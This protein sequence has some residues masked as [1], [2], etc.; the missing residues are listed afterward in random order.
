[1]KTSTCKD[2]YMLVTYSSI[3]DIQKVLDS[4]I[5]QLQMYAF[6]KHDKDKYSKDILQ[7]DTGEVLHKKG[8]IEGTHYHIFLKLK[9]TRKGKEIKRWFEK[10]DSNGIC[11]NN[12]LFKQVQHTIKGTIEYLTHT[13]KSCEGYEEY[14]HVYDKS[15]IFS[16]NIDLENLQQYDCVNNVDES[17]NIILD[18]L[19]GKSTR[20]L[21][22]I[23]G[24]D[25]IYHKRA[26]DEIVYQ[27]QKEEYTDTYTLNVPSNL[28]LESCL[29][30]IENLK[31]DNVIIVNEKPLFES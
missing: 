6:I 16:Y 26:Y 7:S 30:Q 22:L 31:N 11:V 19:A 29:E 21:C 17:Y 3:E 10:F 28:A 12:C 5:E 9:R 18:I 23:Y 1:M 4:K 25:Y 13:S 27:I 20:E 14:K 8:E 15:E 24:K 2:S